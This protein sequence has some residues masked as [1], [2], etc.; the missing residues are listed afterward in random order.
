MVKNLYSFD[1]F[2]TLV[3]RRVATPDGIFSIIQELLKNTKINS[4]LKNNFY[5]IRVGAEEFA[6]L[7]NYQMKSSDEITF[8][9]IYSIIQNNYNINQKQIDFLKQLEISTESKNLIKIDKNLHILKNLVLNNERVV[10]ISD[11]YYGE[12]ILKNILSP[13]DPIFSKIK[14]YSSADY[15][16]TKANFKLYKVVKDIEKVEYINWTHYGDNEDSDIKNPTSLGIKTVYIP[17]E[18]LYKY[19]NDLL[20]S[21][22]SDIYSQVIIGC[23][24]IAKLLKP[25]IN[26]QKYNFGASFSGPILYNYVD[27]IIS[28]SINMGF[29]TLYFV[30]R[31][32]YIPKIIADL[33]IENRNLS[34]KTKYIHGSRLAWRILTTENYN[35]LIENTLREY[36]EQITP[37][38]LAYRFGFDENEM[39]KLLKLKTPSSKIMAKQIDEYINFLQNDLNV[40]QT[41]LKNAELQ[42]TLLKKYLLQEI[43]FQE[44]NIVFI[45]L[46]GSGKTQDCIAEI[47]N[48][49]TPCKLYCFYLSNFTMNQNDISIKL[50]YFTSKNYM[51]HWIELLCRNTEG[52]T[53]GYSEENKKILPVTE[54]GNGDLM[55]EWGF[56][57]YLEGI[58][59]YTKAILATEKVNN[60]SFCTLKLYCKYFDYL[61]KKIDYQTA[62]I[63]GQIPFLSIGKEDIAALEAAPGIRLLDVIKNFMLHKK[64]TSY[65]DFPYI[66]KARTTKICQ[67][68]KNVIDDC[69]TRR[70][71]FFDICTGKNAY[72]RILGIKLFFR[73]VIKR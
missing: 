70:K 41:L 55:L 5:R 28:Q 66:S 52:Q 68:V 24:K 64:K 13:L 62:T 72:I 1:I 51:S 69:P 71:F 46:W 16:V 48:Q 8:D 61:T 54:K 27:W 21:N 4:F 73:K 26:Y 12:K 30:A 59:N 29:K 67:K 33:I 17:K 22:L 47:L 58:V 39:T 23:S 36:C 10:L 18:K 31:D 9:E 37:A 34:I 35:S 65:G 42:I 49:I 15:K 63:I 38:F 6:R 60:M 25:K 20:N 50:S 3:T 19:E 44:K 2:D 57:Q 14:I 11:M 56:N 53:I 32:G 40:K 45:D 43:N 7:K